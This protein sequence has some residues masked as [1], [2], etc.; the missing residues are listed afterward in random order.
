MQTATG[1]GAAPC[2]CAAVNLS[3]TPVEMSKQA[4]HGLILKQ[5]MK[6][7]LTFVESQEITNEAQLN[8]WQVN[9]LT[10]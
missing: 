2:Q 6:I 4:T 7:R 9:E 10:H 3:Q 8:H 1:S 5:A